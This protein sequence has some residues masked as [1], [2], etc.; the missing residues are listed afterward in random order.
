[1]SDDEVKEQVKELILDHQGADDPITSREIN[2][3]VE[4]DAVGSF[5]ST[6]SVIR[7]LVLEDTVPIAASSNGYYVIQDQDELEHYVENLENRVM[8]IT[9]RKFAVQRAVLEW[10]DEILDD[11][12]DLL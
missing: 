9:E 3:Q 8:Q 12:A 2:E 1:M 11:D 7:E 10:D 5:P 6:R 4:L